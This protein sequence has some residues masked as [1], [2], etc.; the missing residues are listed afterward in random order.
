MRLTKGLY[1]GDIAFVTRTSLSLL[2]DVLV[3]PRVTYEPSPKK[4][5]TTSVTLADLKE[6]SNFARDYNP[7]RELWKK[8][9]PDRPSQSVF[10]TDLAKQ[11]FP[12]AFQ[13]KS[14][15][16]LFKGILYDQDG[17]AI[18]KA[19]D[20]DRYIPEDAVLSA[21]EYNLFSA[22]SSISAEV[23]EKTAK[24]ITSRSFRLHD[25]VKV[26]DGDSRGLFGRIIDLRENEADLFLPLDG[27]TSTIPLTSLRKDLRVGDEVRVESGSHRG[28][29]GWVVNKDD[30]SVWLFNHE[31]GI[32]VRLL[33]LSFYATDI[34]LDRSF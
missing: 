32:E 20:T 22:C 26:V 7:N 29:T 33:P 2:I 4:G 21:E 15:F 1:K 8:W 17:Y 12:R 13:W 11:R 5:V 25:A 23:R 14:P 19:L 27:Q 24:Q 10:N 9:G 6:D 18:L 3:L 34:Y 16:S 31:T 28:V 30:E